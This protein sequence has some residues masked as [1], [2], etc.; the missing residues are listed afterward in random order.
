MKRLLVGVAGYLAIAT[1]AGFDPMAG[2]QVGAGLWIV[3]IAWPTVAAAWA[4][5]SKRTARRLRDVAD[6]FAEPYGDR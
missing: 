5:P 6:P 3:A 1:A 2:A 4:Q